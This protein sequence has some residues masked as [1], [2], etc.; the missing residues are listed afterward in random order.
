MLIALWRF[1]N[2]PEEKRSDKA[3]PFNIKVHLE[4]QWHFPLRR[5]AKNNR[6]GPHHSDAHKQHL[7]MTLPARNPCLDKALTELLLIPY[8]V[9]TVM[10]SKY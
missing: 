9:I 7:M 10:S 2:I 6:W 3:V 5:R 1:Q 4:R 8:T